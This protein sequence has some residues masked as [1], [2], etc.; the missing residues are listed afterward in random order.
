MASAVGHCPEQSIPPVRIRVATSM[1]KLITKADTSVERAVLGRERSPSGMVVGRCGNKRRRWHYQGGDQFKAE[2][3]Y[4][5]Q[6]LVIG[7]GASTRD[8]CGAAVGIGHLSSSF[9]IASVA[10]NQSLEN[11]FLMRCSLRLSNAM[12]SSLKRLNILF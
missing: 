6:A 10:R 1:S 5:G 3:H 9:L 8:L 4:P 11:E 12:L 7:A 2:I